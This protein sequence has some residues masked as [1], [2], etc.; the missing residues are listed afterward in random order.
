MESVRK[1][2]S[3]WRRISAAMHDAV[4][5]H[6]RATGDTEQTLAD[7]C[8]VPL[9]TFSNYLCG[10]LATPM[11]LAVRLTNLTGRD[12]VARAFGSLTNNLIIPMPEPGEHP[13]IAQVLQE[14]GDVLRVYGEAI[15]DGMITEGEAV[16]LVREIEEA[17]AALEAMKQR[18]KASEVRKPQLRLK[19]VM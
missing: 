6:C 5:A 19:G 18:V 16:R 10:H 7:D 11:D 3:A 8:G 13:E 14:T 4:T 12:E 17:Q 15:Q 2:S 9:G 1:R